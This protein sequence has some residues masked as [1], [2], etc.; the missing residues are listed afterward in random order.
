MEIKDFFKE[1][2]EVEQKYNFFEQEIQG[3]KPWKYLRISS[4]ELWDEMGYTYYDSH[5]INN[6]KS[7]D[8]QR[9]IDRRNNNESLKDRF[10]QDGLK[11][12]HSDVLYF[13]FNTRY[14]LFD[15]DFNNYID[16][17]ILSTPDDLSYTVLEWSLRETEHR[18]LNP[19]TPNLQYISHEMIIARFG[20]NP[21]E[22]YDD[23][24]DEMEEKFFDPI[25]KEMK[26]YIKYR[27]K[28]KFVYDVVCHLQFEDAYRKY[29]EYILK[30]VNPSIVMFYNPHEISTRVLIDV[31][32][33]LGIVVCE[34]SHGFVKTSPMYCSNIEKEL[35]YPDYVISFGTELINKLSRESYGC[36]YGVG[37][38][39]IIPIGKPLLSM[40][41]QFYN[42]ITDKKK[43]ETKQILIIG[44]PLESYWGF[45][46]SLS[47][48]LKG[49][50]V[51]A[52]YKEH[53]TEY[54]RKISQLIKAEENGIKI[55][56]QSYLYEL[57]M[58]SDYIIGYT[59][60]AVIESARL[61]KKPI[62][63]MDENGYSEYA[64]FR[65][66][67]PVRNA[68]ECIKKLKD[69][70][71][72]WYSTDNIEYFYCSD[73]EEKYKK[74]LHDVVAKKVS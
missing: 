2:L 16:D 12:E 55:I 69:R 30:Q 63:F 64:D 26:F 15:K 17:Y 31:C 42:S 6:F 7:A 50:N 74:F 54:N 72:D 18:A 4:F 21:I 58:N 29:Y 27:T 47:E 11:F 61:G 56:K 53:G 41:S 40:V 71:D 13:T 68:D 45:V 65:L 37:E 52:L 51:T 73:P 33:K 62:I 36:L 14:K 44:T 25:E 34:I 38:N 67:Y 20:S 8:L 39:N 49:L 1:L 46:E 3:I 9:A 19:A 59:S 24:Y 28:K 70:N 35:L 60:T 5:W 23:I 10:E 22:D 57:I 32:K 66:A 48:K 43:D